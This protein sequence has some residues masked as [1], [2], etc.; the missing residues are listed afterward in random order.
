MSAGGRQRLFEDCSDK[1][2]LAENVSALH[3]VFNCS[4][5]YQQVVEVGID[6]S[7]RPAPGFQNELL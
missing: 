5:C 7:I 4:W 1:K 2:K 6:I 3:I